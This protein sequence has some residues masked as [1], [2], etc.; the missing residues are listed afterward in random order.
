MR[1]KISVLDFV[2]EDKTVIHKR[3]LRELER[4]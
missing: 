2:L 4:L 3:T 1:I